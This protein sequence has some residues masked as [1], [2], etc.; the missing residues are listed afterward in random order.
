[1]SNPEKL[2]NALKA[3]DA[4]CELL[5]SE[6]LS[7]ST[8][9]YLLELRELLAAELAELESCGDKLASA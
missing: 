4:V 6:I 9:F 3:H 2:A 8:R 1:M 5:K 7:D